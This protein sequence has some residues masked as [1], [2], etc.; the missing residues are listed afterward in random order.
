[1]KKNEHCDLAEREAEFWRKHHRRRPQWP[2]FNDPDKFFGENFLVMHV[3]EAL[4]PSHEEL[5]VQ[6]QGREEA[7]YFTYD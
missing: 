2:T 1:M 6:Q 3:W 7:F 4:L 5:K